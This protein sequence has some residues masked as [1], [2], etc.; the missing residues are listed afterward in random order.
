MLIVRSNN[1]RECPM[2]LLETAAPTNARKLSSV[3]DRLNVTG[4]RAWKVHFA[5]A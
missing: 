3:V 2:S 5:A 1:K 4:S